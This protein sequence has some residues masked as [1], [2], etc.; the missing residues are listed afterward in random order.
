MGRVLVLALTMIFGGYAAVAEDEVLVRI[1]TYN[2]KFLDAAKL[3]NEGNRQDK[4]QELIGALDAHVI[5]LQEIANTAALRTIFPSDEW[6]VMIDEDSGDS[7]DVA[8]AVRNPLRVKGVA[9]A[10]RDI[11]AD[12]QN[13]LFPDAADNSLFPGRRDVLFAEIEVPGVSETF[14][15]FVLHPKARVGGRAA[16]DF[17][18]EGAAAQLLQKLEQEFHEQNVVLLGDLN[19]NP[20]DRSLNILETGDPDAAGGPQDATGPFLINLAEALL[21]DDRVSH[22][23]TSQDIVNGRVDTVD[24]GSR[25]R[26]NDLRGTD[27]HTGDILFDQILIPPRLSDNY[28]Q[29]SIHIF[30]LPVAMEG[31]SQT[32]ASDHLPVFAEFSFAAGTPEDV[33]GVRIISLLPD[34]EGRDEGHEEV[35]LRNLGQ[36]AVSLEAWK[37][38]DRAQNEFQLS[39]QIQGGGELVVT[40]TTFSM[41]LNNSGDEVS[42]FDSSDTLVHKVSYE[43]AQV[44]R[45]TVITFE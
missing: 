37:L 22:G 31:N 33:A 20:D 19:D 1:A 13:F 6:I 5:G 9:A 7:Q 35:T 32:R 45:G 41:P 28:V 30:D 17:R 40:M 39:G 21:L 11:D 18:R 38:R 24:P 42:V 26:N 16:T 34:P 44:A 36:A 29:D 2:I 25:K 27:E 15:V 3:P 4:L 8:I 43:A 14:F 10:T 12:P 23:R